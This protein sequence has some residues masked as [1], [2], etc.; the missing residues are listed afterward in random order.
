MRPQRALIAA[1]RAKRGSWPSSYG[2]V[3]GA[4]AA[5]SSADVL[6]LRPALRARVSPVDVPIVRGEIAGGGSP[7]LRSAERD[8]WRAE[9]GRERWK[10][11][12]SAECESSDPFD[13]ERPVAV[14]PSTLSAETFRLSTE[15]SSSSDALDSAL[16]ATLSALVGR[17]APIEAR[18]HAEPPSGPP[19]AVPARIESSWSL[20]GEQTPFRGEHSVG[21]RGDE[22]RGLR[23]RTRFQLSGEAPGGA[24]LRIIPAPQ[25]TASLIGGRD[26]LGNRDGGC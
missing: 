9:T 12:L 5:P 1:G 10:K 26:D 17:D 14:G 23:L 16:D 19:H 2:S 3:A 7:A 22:A 18:S 20:S 24:P 15:T 6:A 25:W 11:L 13:D 21:A 4:S 8:I